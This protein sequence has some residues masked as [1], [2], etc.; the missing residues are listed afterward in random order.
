VGAGAKILGPF[1]VGDNARIG[2]NAVVLEEV[3]RGATVVGVPGRVVACRDDAGQP[4]IELV[5]E[6]KQRKDSFDAYGVCEEDMQSAVE[7]VASMREELDRL[8]TTVESLEKSLQIQQD[9]NSELPNARTGTS[10][11]QNVL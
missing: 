11:D 7:D 9:R 1:K 10:A 6:K 5:G 4:C 2:S 8:R 3:P